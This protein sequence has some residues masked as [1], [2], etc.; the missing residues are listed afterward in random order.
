MRGG[1]KDGFILVAVLGIMALLLSL[2]GGTALLVR[3]AI[4][5]V[6]GTADDLKLEALVRAG[7]DL[8]GHELFDL[9]LPTA[10]IR[11]Q[12]IDLDGGTITLFAS[13]E[14]G[15]IDL[16]GPIPSCLQAPTGWPD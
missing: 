16:N 13:D 9:K 2:A 7:I 1:R 3:S 6:H 5:G 10:R 11:D 4:N 12:R 8:A 14:S 15:L